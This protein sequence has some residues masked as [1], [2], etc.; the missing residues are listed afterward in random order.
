MSTEELPGGSSLRVGGV[1]YESDSAE[2]TPEQHEE[3]LRILN[4]FIDLDGYNNPVDYGDD[5]R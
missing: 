2:I 4:G 5:R 1:N 3:N